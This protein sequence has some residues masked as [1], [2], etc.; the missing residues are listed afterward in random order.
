MII[1]DFIPPLRLQS[2]IKCFRIVHFQFDPSQPVPSKAYPPKPEQVIHFLLKDPLRIEQSDGTC[3]ISPAIM[4]SGQQTR[5]VNQYTSADFMDV[6]I[7]FTSTAVHQLT[8]ISAQLLSNC[9]IDATALFPATTV[10]LDQLRTSRNYDDL[11]KTL[12]QYCEELLK[13]TRAEHRLFNAVCEQM[14]TMHGNVSID[15]LASEACYSLK[16]FQR[17]F[18]VQIGVN[19]KTY[20]RILRLNRAFNI[21]NCFPKRTWTGIA[22]TC[23]FQDYQHLAKDYKEFTGYSPVELHLQEKRSPENVLGIANSLYRNRAGFASDL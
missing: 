22:S 21:R 17:I 20:A 3:F 14:I 15:W 19:P 18:N 16:Q 5:L 23:G 1:Q 8:G 6:Q 4:F 11:I 9:F 12:E 2:L 10:T 7:V 13:H